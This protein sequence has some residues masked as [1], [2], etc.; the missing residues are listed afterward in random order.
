VASVRSRSDAGAPNLAAGKVVFVGFMGS[1]KSRAARH[2][3]RAL[4]AEA[5]D[6]DALLV[7]EL[8]EPIASF[9]DRNGEAAFRE[10]EE[11]IVL[12][13]LDDPEVRIVAIGG[14][15][16]LSEQVRER[17]PSHLCIHMEVEPEV[18]WERA[19]KSERPLARDR[20]RFLELFRERLPLYESVARAV[21]PARDDLIERALPAALKLSTPGV[22]SAR[23][24]RTDTVLALGGGVVGDLA[25]FCAAVYQRGVAHV[26]V[27]T[28]LLAQVDSAYGGKTGVDLPEAKN[29]VGAFHEP[30]AVLADTALLQTL[31]PAELRAGFSEVIKTALIAGGELWPAVVR[32]GSIERALQDDAPAVQAVIVGCLRTKLNVVAEDEHD[33]GLRASLNLGHTFAH[34]LEAAGGYQ[35]YRHGEAVGLGMLVALRLSEQQL[36]LEASVRDQVANLLSGSGLPTTFSGPSADEI[37]DHAALDKKRR[38]GRRNLVLL[39][40]PGS[41]RIGCEVSDEELREAIEEIRDGVRES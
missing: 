5:L 14:G 30:D 6:S 13:L 25:G 3:S 27:P 10:K 39:E 11:R 36:G 32:L 9:F 35:G 15:A 41:V 38:Q 23:L 33:R 1:G 12:D 28:T 29:Y 8:G 4:G 21:V 2:A 22:A 16:V 40:S 26:Q 34:A 37:I 17:L 7:A 24:Q 31:P 20:D 19:Q 18:S